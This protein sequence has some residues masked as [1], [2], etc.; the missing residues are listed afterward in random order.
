MPLVLVR[1]DDRLIH[2]QVVVGWGIQLSPNRII[3]SSDEI[4]SSSWEKEMYMGA[5]ATAPFPLAISVLTI[6]ET[7]LFLTENQ[8]EKTILL[9]EAPK[10]ILALIE[11]GL[12]IE[13]VN[14]GGMHYKPGKRRL[15][16]YIFVD[17][18]DITAFKKMRDMNIELAGQ[19]VPTAKKI[20]ILKALKA[21]SEDQL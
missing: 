5:E 12:K 9:V 11:K 13:K 15:A 10:E 18:E 8:T 2:G 14:V 17:E 7:I 19:D 4:A 3:L 16:P 21:I 1:I 20:D 6:D